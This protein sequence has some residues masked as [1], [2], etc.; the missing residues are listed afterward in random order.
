[1]DMEMEE[2]LGAAINSSTNSISSSLLHNHRVSDGTGAHTLRSQ[3]VSQGSRLTSISNPLS[4]AHIPR[5]TSNHTSPPLGLLLTQHLHS[6]QP[7]FTQGNA[8]PYTPTPP[9]PP[10]PIHSPYLPA[11]PPSPEPLS[12]C[13]S[14]IS[15]PYLPAPPPSPEPLS[16]CTSSIS[17]PYSQPLPPHTSSMSNPYPQPISPCTSSISSPYPQPISPH[18]SSISRTPIP[19][20]LLHLQPLSPAPIPAHLLHLQPLSTGHIPHTCSISSP[21]PPSPPPPAPIHSPYPL[22]HIQL[23]RPQGMLSIQQHLQLSFT[24]SQGVRLCI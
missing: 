14:S 22:Q 19:A 23:H 6:L 3:T 4:T 1:M 24:H 20:H 18:T 11:P 2:P 8:S 12:P 9:P 5:R 21:Y 16:P 15:S 13:T 10:A 7:S 17:S